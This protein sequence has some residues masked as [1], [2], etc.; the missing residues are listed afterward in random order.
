MKKFL[1][2]ISVSL[3]FV[4]RLFTRD[5]KKKKLL[6]RSSSLSRAQINRTSATKMQTRAQEGERQIGERNLWD[7]IVNNDDISF[8]HIL[9]R[10][11]QNDTRYDSGSKK[12]SLEIVGIDPTTCRMYVYGLY[13]YSRIC[14]SAALPFELYPPKREKRR[15][16]TTVSRLCL[17]NL[18]V[19]DFFKTY[20]KLTKRYFAENTQ[21]RSNK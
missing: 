4:K 2:F 13:I 8:T 21:G 3:F 7:L 5:R 10:L 17:H 20:N 9:P 15:Q 11:N 1:H 19:S 6:L 14:E 12:K 18:T 16:K